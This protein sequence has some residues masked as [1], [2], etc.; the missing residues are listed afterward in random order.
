MGY[1]PASQCASC[2][3]SSVRPLPPGWESDARWCDPCMTRV[4]QETPWWTPQML[5]WEAWR[6]IEVQCRYCQKKYLPP[7]PSSLICPECA[8]KHC[9]RCGKG[10]N[11]KDVLCDSCLWDIE[12]EALLKYG[13][14]KILDKEGY[15]G[16]N[17]RCVICLGKGFYANAAGFNNL[18]Q[19][20]KNELA[21]H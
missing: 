17:P 3:S 16:A 10:E 7:K 15:F 12:E 6:H 14:P 13:P 1:N 19:C 2:G 4:K 5:A 9:P 21:H 11:L 8:P 18:C 20:R